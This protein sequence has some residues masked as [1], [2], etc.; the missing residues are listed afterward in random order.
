MT[1]RGID[2]VL[3]FSSSPEIYEGWSEDAREYV[4]LAERVSGPIPERVEYEYVW[5]RAL[6]ELSARKPDFRVVNLET[7]V[8][9]SDA[10]EEK[11]INY[12]MHP[13]NVR[14]LTVAGVDCAVLSNNHVLDWG[15]AG[16]LETLDTLHATGIV[17][18]GA[19]R[20]AE[21]ASAPAVLS[22]RGGTRVLVYGLGTWSS[23]IPEEWSATSQR[24]GVN[25]LP[26]FSMET[27]MVFAERVRRERRPEDWV[28]VSIHWGGNWGYGVP[29]K[30]RRFAHA[31]IDEAGVDVVH[32]HS[33]HHA[34]ALEVYRGRPILYGCGDFINDYEGI[35]GHEEYRDD[36]PLMYFTEL[37][38]REHQLSRLTMVPLH[39]EK[40]RLERASAQDSRWLANVLS[41]EGL[42]FGTRV[43][44]KGGALELD[45]AGR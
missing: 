5:G 26:D 41:S 33:S 6:E 12:R 4:E 32:G 16:L 1:G 3:P 2:Q 15:E 44:A 42:S 18:A 39:L 9:T 28:V 34:K 22:V 10:H 45:W 40:F 13:R 43:E 8:T 27:A 7:S 20:S 17:T 19:G 37:D 35:T 23:G 24:P 11:G 14:V 36:L 25:Y 30:H 38:A 31:L 29:E 21:E